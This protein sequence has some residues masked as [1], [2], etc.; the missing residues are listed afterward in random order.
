MYVCICVHI[1]EHSKENTNRIPQKIW[2]HATWKICKILI[3]FPT[4]TWQ[5]AYNIKQ[6]VITLI[7][8]LNSLFYRFVLIITFYIYAKQQFL[9]LNKIILILYCTINTCFYLVNKTYKMILLWNYLLV[10]SYSN[11]LIRRFNLSHLGVYAHLYIYM[12]T[13]LIIWEVFCVLIS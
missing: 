10:S 12:N 6:I 11:C 5:Q 4:S 2:R 1:W 8:K 3:V 13:V 9:D 7:Y